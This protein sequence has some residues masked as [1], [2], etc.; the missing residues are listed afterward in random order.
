MLALCLFN[1]LILLITA[2]EAKKKLV[3]VSNIRMGVSLFFTLICGMSL[4][5]LF[6]SSSSK[7]LK[8]LSANECSDDIIMNRSF[9]TM[10]TYFEGLFVNNIITSLIFILIVVVQVGFGV[11]SWYC[12]TTKAKRKQKKEMKQAMEEFM[13]KK[14]AKINGP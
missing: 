9:V 1:F 7:D 2:K 13:I 11:L 12:N 3:K 6:F 4:F 8:Y 14:M 5:F 10:H